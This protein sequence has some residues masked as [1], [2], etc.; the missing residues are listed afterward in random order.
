MDI[1]VL[2]GGL[3]PERDVSL[4]SGCKIA[5]ALISRGHRV[6][7][8]DLYMGLPHARGF[9]DAYNKFKKDSYEFKVPEREPDLAAIKKDRAGALGT[10]SEV[11]AGCSGG[12]Y[13]NA[14]LIGDGIVAAC[15]SADITFN[16]LHGDIGENGRLQALFDIYGI[17]Y[18]GSGYEGCHL[19]MDKP[20]A[21]ELMRVNGVRTPEYEII[22]AGSGFDPL[23]GKQLGYPCVIKPCGCGSSVGVSI[24]NNRSELDSALKYA[25]IYEKRIMAEHKIE[26][27][28]FSVGVLGDEALPPIEIIPQTGFYDYVN[29]YQPGAALEVCPPVGLAPEL[30][31]VM[32]A[33]ALKVHGTLGLSGYSRLDLILDGEG[34]INCLEINTLPGMTPTSLLP[35]EAAAAGVPYNELCERIIQ[36]ALR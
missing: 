33:T 1:V 20:L 4:S 16:A 14:Q 35:Q 13:N 30:E 12:L 27:R 19:A 18:T 15:A 3:S 25:F 29:K 26:G 36:L 2:A 24:V 5:N 17:K 11:D 21:K 31:K 10:H 32:R 9:G 28:E 34:E 22:T 7:L 6:L 8:A 23:A